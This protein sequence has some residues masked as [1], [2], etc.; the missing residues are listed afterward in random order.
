MPQAITSLCISEVSLEAG[1]RQKLEVRDQD[2][3]SS[4]VEGEVDWLQQ[5]VVDHLLQLTAEARVAV[6]R[7]EELKR[8]G[9]TAPGALERQNSSSPANYVEFAVYA[10]AV[11]PGKSC[12]LNLWVYLLDQ[13]AA[14]SERAADGGRLSKLEG[15]ASGEELPLH[16]PLL[17]TIE[18]S[19]ACR[20]IVELQP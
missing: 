4:T 9:T 18:S 11:W 19:A 13:H 7:F 8:N 15:D 14:I 3:L 16:V 20:A 1:V 12:F 10:P 6:R 17:A 5:H 2:D